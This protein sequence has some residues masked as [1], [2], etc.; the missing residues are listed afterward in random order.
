MLQHKRWQDCRLRWT[1]HT[2]EQWKAKEGC[3]VRKQSD[4]TT[5]TLEAME[6]AEAHL[7]KGCAQ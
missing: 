1:A 4:Y 6:V 5:G 3:V 2:E 7:L